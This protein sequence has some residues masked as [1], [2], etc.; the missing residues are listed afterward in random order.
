MSEK[1]IK[2]FFDQSGL[3]YKD[4][5]LTTHFPIVG[6]GFLGASNTTKIRFYF[7]NIGTLNDTYLAVSKLPNGKQGSQLLNI[8]SSDENGQYAELSLSE[9]YFQAKGDVFIG[10]KVYRGGVEVEIDNETGFSIVSGDPVIMVTGSI[11]L[12]INYAPIGDVPDYRDE[13]TAYNDILA[14]MGEKPDIDTVPLLVNFSDYATWG[15][16][17]EYVGNRPFVAYVN[18]VLSVCAIESE[19]SD[20]ELLVNN[21]LGIFKTGTLSLD[22]AIGDEYGA[23]AFEQYEEINNNVIDLTGMSG[24]LTSEQQELISKPNAYIRKDFNSLYYKMSVDTFLH[25]SL[26]EYTDYVTLFTG[27]IVIDTSSNP[28]TWTQTNKSTNI[29]KKEKVDSLVSGLET[30]INASGHSL[31][32]TIDNQTYIMTISLK[33]KN[34]NVISTQQVDL[35]L[36]SIVT[37]ATYY[38]E[39]S[40]GGV[41][42][43]K[44]IVIVL[45]TTPVPTIVPVG[46]LVEGLI[47]E[48]TL[49]TTLESYVKDVEIT[50]I[51]TVAEV[52]E[53]IGG[54]NHIFSFD[55]MG[56][57]Y[58]GLFVEGQ[59][60]DTDLELWSPSGTSKVASIDTTQLFRN[61]MSNAVVESSYFPIVSLSNPITTLSDEQMTILGQNNSVISYGGRLYYKSNDAGGSIEFV[62]PDIDDTSVVAFGSHA[63]S[64][65]EITVNKSTKGTNVITITNYYYDKTQTDTL[66]GNK[67]NT[68]VSGQNIKTIN[69]ESLLGSGN[70]N[71]EGGS[72][73]W[74]SIGG[75]ISDQT[76][77][78]TE[79]TNIRE[80][81]EG[82]C[83]AYT[84]RYQATAPQN[85][86]EA[87]RYYYVNENNEMVSFQSL[88]DFETYIDGLSLL[89]SSFN[90]QNSSIAIFQGSTLGGYLILNELDNADYRLR[91]IKSSDFVGMVNT[92]DIIYV[93]ETN[94][95]DRWISKQASSY[96]AACYIL[97]TSKVDL[98]N[99]A[100][101]TEVNAKSDL[102]NVAPTYDNTLTYTIGEV[103]SYNGKIYRCT[104]AITQAEDW[105]STH[106]TETSVA[107]DFVNLTG[108]Q[109]IS[110]AKNHTGPLQKN[111]VDV[112]TTDELSFPLIA[113][114][115]S[116]TLTDE[117]IAIISNGCRINGTFLGLTN[118]VFLPTSTPQF[119]EI[120]GVVYEGKGLSPMF[121][122]YSINTNSKVINLYIGSQ[123][124]RLKINCVNNINGVNI[125]QYYKK[126]QATVSL[127]DGGTITDNALKAL[128]QNEQPIK[129]NGYTCYFS[130]DDGTKYQYVSTR[131]DPNANKNHINVIIIDKYTWVA[132]FHTS[133]IAV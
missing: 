129:L 33:D 120:A 40:Y 58:L 107:S 4:K 94:V 133:D 101:K 87:G 13:F 132:N 126:P 30:K 110:G 25:I 24:T 9:W 45:A 71:I 127:S 43:E 104:T 31:S 46:A 97:E 73:E 56:I 130:C 100:T 14:L 20:Y 8:K 102:T 131:Y 1:V 62:C 18:G 27:T 29:Y 90:S 108:T 32:A 57:K 41:D 85:D 86:N 34:N 116:T 16:L 5:E 39:Y 79:L 75:D 81:A 3:P 128:I 64:K 65:Y 11:K 68:L 44:V 114:P 49:D 112:A 15:A 35:P 12:A 63:Q 26:V 10:L 77:L 47:T 53:E 36:E 83:K 69:N 76:D 67:Q 119:D 91:V 19:D 122:V 17:Y 22:S 55:L 66:L 78:Q 23:I 48:E 54:N 117:Q 61:E 124:S 95:P 92:G 72:A 99:Y 109:T 38:D 103:V 7:E 93:I 89:N 113:A 82:K 28:Y 59:G 84:L 50:S 105:D 106:W 80:V 125:N 115:T 123:A 6:S 2:V 21:S 42:Y 121:A 74:G 88:Q 37:S 60:T 111:G 98:T 51:K 70:I 52:L 118:P 96:V